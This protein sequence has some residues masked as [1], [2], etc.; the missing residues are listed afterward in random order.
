[1]GTEIYEING[2]AITRFF[3]GKERGSCYQLTLNREYIHL[4][5]A[6]FEK[7]L[8][9]VL[10]KHIEARHENTTVNNIMVDITTRIKLMI[11]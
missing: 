4:T 8:Y 1:M 6:E 2:F 5:E 7:M 9:D 10:K 11:P 3:G